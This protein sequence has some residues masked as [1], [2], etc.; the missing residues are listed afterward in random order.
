MG[1][2]AD[3]PRLSYARL[4]LIPTSSLRFLGGPGDRRQR[5]FQRNGPLPGPAYAAGPH[6]AAS[7]TAYWTASGPGPSKAQGPGPRH[8][9]LENLGR[10]QPLHAGRAWPCPQHLRALPQGRARNV[11]W[12]GHCTRGFVRAYSLTNPALS[13]LSRGDSR[14]CSGFSL[15]KSG[16]L[17]KA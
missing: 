16:L 5:P 4:R 15:T 6:P 7:S 17:S 2:I 12:S 8:P 11:L 3:Q 13:P 9:A 10:G 14:L 1:I